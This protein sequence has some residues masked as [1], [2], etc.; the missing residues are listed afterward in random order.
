MNRALNF[1][2]LTQEFPREIERARRIIA[3]VARF[4]RQHL[5]VILLLRN[6]CNPRS[7]CIIFHVLVVENS[8]FLCMHVRVCPWNYSLANSIRDIH[9]HGYSSASQRTNERLLTN[10]ICDIFVMHL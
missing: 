4:R 10:Y 9:E 6:C 3:F 1:R 2:V 7:G 8:L 5:P